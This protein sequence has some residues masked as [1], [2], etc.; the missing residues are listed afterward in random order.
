MLRR[1]MLA[2]NSGVWCKS[3]LSRANP[4]KLFFITYGFRM[5][6]ERSK[7]V[8]NKKS[9]RSKLIGRAEELLTNVYQWY[10]YSD[11]EYRA[12]LKQEFDTASL[13][14]MELFDVECEVSRNGAVHLVR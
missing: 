14:A 9:E 10:L 7:T 8:A 4:W 3:P 13:F 5:W 12:D 2:F 6:S 1:E 11:E